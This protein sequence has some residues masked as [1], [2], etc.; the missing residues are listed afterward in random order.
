VAHAQEGGER[1]GLERAGKAANEVELVEAQL[2]GDLERR[3]EKDMGRGRC[4]GSVRLIIVINSF[5]TVDAKRGSE[6]RL[7][8]GRTDRSPAL[9]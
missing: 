9:D 4:Y 3:K 8:I 2:L 7:S 1:V 6:S 5:G